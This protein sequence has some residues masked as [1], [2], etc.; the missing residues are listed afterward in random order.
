MKSSQ[1][2]M[3]VHAM[4]KLSCDWVIGRGTDDG[5][6]GASRAKGRIALIYPLLDF[7]GRKNL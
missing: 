2:E 7:G 1:E 5:I 4:E 6:D 3:R